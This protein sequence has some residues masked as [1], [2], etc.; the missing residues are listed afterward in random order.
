MKNHKQIKIFIVDDNNV[1]AQAMKADIE[2]A[3]IAMPLKIFTFENGEKCME[4]LSKEKPQVVILDYHLNNII[5]KSVDGIKVLDWIKK[6]DEEINVIM[7]TRDDNIEIAIKSFKHG[8]SDY[9]VKSDTQFRKVIYTLFNLFKLMEAKKNEKRYKYIAFLTIFFI[10]LIIFT[11]V[12]I[13]IFNP[14]LFLR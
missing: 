12:M 3:F 1:F 5:T 9:I 2:S 11:V 4:V 8:A 10:A 14:A 13:Q 6:E 7:L